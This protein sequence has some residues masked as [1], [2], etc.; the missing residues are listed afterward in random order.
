[1]KLPCRICGDGHAT[2]EKARKCWET[3]KRLEA[4]IDI[5]IQTRQDSLTNFYKLG[6]ALLKPPG[7]SFDD[8]L[9]MTEFEP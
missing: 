2:A 4:W 8:K 7:G 1:V 5:A 9:P 6:A 3:R